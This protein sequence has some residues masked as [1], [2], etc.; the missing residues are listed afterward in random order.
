M[1]LRPGQRTARAARAATNVNARADRSN[2]KAAAVA[3]RILRCVLC[4]LCILSSA[5]G[6]TSLFRQ[7]EYEEDLY[8]SLDGTATIYVNS[9]IAA[10]N[11]LRGTSFDAS[12]AT[13]VD[14]NAVRGYYTTPGTHVTR[15][16]PFRRSSRRFVSVR[17]AVDDIR[18]LGEAAP[19]AWS[20]YRFEQNDHQYTYLQTVGA[21]AGNHPGNVGWNGRELVGFRLHL[22]SKIRYHNTRGVESR[23]NILAW[24]QPLADRLRGEPLSIEA[25][26]DTQSILYTTLWLFGIT[27][28]VV[29]AAFAAVIW[30]VMR[31]GAGPPVAP[32]R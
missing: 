13:R 24:E 16:S 10:L 11:A 21:A 7:Y 32:A 20:T 9:S 25:R 18:R 8:L 23:G 26:M 17:I 14:T 31:R 5:C 12:P 2:T 1:R 6:N 27:F 28:V 3:E 30:W 15:V 22:P 29:A 4:G 19:F